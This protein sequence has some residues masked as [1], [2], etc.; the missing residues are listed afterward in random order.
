MA[1][2]APVLPA[3]AAASA[4]LLATPPLLVPKSKERRTS[5]GVSGAATGAAVSPGVVMR[6]TL[7]LEITDSTDCG[8]RYTETNRPSAQVVWLDR[9]TLLQPLYYRCG[10]VFVGR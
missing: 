9:V 2:P 1:V 6:S 4:K 7:P 10:V 3:P 5:A 8:T